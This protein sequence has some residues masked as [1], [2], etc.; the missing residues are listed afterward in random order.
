LG[1]EFVVGQQPQR[2][3]RVVGEQVSFVDAQDGHSS[4]FCVCGGECVAGLGYQR[5][6]VEAGFAAEGHDEVVVD[7]SR[8]HGGVGDVDQVVAGGFGAVDGR[9][10]GHGLADADLAGDHGD[11]AG[12]DAVGDAGDGLGVVVAVKQHPR[13]EAAAVG[14]GGEAVERLD[15]VQHRCLRVL[16]GS[17]GGGDGDPGRCDVGGV[18]AAED[19]T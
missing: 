5:G 15:L 12:V 9:S 13:R 4:P 19:L 6:G 14:H 17:V 2:F 16:S 11:A 3:E 1:V 7:P 18:E 10:G 8:G